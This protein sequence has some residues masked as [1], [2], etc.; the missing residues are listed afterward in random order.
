MISYNAAIIACEK[1]NQ[2]A[3]ALDLLQ[4]MTNS[5]IEPN[6]IS[7]SAA[8]SAC[9]KGSQWEKA[10]GLLQEMTNSGIE[11]NVISYSAAIKACVVA[12][13]YVEALSLG[14]RG[15]KGGLYPIFLTQSSLVWDLHSLPLAVACAL[16][17]DSLLQVLRE[18]SFEEPSFTNI[19]VVTGKGLEVALA[20]R[21][22]GPRLQS[23]CRKRLDQK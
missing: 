6:V 1:G 19:A 9:E 17:I 4:E 14:R 10:L 21:F 3:K 15:R 23:F 18:G 12:E 13:Q 5:G 8:I 22:Y 7:Y 2:W 11:P 16:L 20:D